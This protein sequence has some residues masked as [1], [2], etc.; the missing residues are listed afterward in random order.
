MMP[1]KFRWLN[2][3]RFRSGYVLLMVLI[4]LTVLTTALSSMA[5]R[6]MQTSQEAVIAEA[7]LQQRVGMES[8]KKALMPT[9]SEVFNSMDR[10]RRGTSSSSAP[11]HVVADSIVLG[12][13]RFDIVLADENAKINLNTMYH[14]TGKAKLDRLLREKLSVG[15]LQALALRPAIPSIKDGLARTR[16]GADKGGKQSNA[17]SSDPDPSSDESAPIQTQLPPAFRSWGEVFD[18]EVLIH[19]SAE[20]K[21]R[22]DFANSFTLWGSGQINID[23]ATEQA[24]TTTV[25]SILGPAEAKL[26]VGKIMAHDDVDIQAVIEKEV[27]KASNRPPLR[28]LIGKHS[29]AFSMF[30]DVVAPQCRSRKLFVESVDSNGTQQISE[31]VFH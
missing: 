15:D 22:V 27:N 31:F 4:L 29:F 16:E 8:C 10:L 1:R 13:Q 20:Q 28:A 7:L 26:I 17:K 24:T 2:R 23:R 5:T 21:M 11:K 3:T 19:Q 6:S 18:L 30:V 14:L 25:E 12:G 9:V